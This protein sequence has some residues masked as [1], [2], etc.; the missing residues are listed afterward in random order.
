L[1]RQKE[2]LNRLARDTAARAELSMFGVKPWI[3]REYFEISNVVGR[4]KELGRLQLKKRQASFF[5]RNVV[6]LLG[7]GSRALL[8]LIVA[9]QPN[10]FEMPISQLTFLE[11]SVEDIFNTIGRLRNMISSAIIQDMFRIRNLFE[12]MEFK[13]KVSAP[14]NPAS[15]KSGPRGMKLEVKDVSFGYAE[16]SPPVIKNVSFVVE[17]GQIVSIV[18]YN[19]S[20]KTTLIR[21][22]TMLEKPT[23]GDIYINDI[24]VSEYDPKILRANMSILFQDFC[25]P[26][27]SDLIS[28]KFTD[29]TAKE[30]IGFGNVDTIDH[31]DMVKKAAGESGAHDFIRK[32]RSYFQTR[33][34]E[35][36]SADQFFEHGLFDSYRRG[37]R[38]RYDDDEEEIP[39]MW[40]ILNDGLQYQAKYKEKLILWEP[41][42]KKKAISVRIAKH[43]KTEPVEENTG[44]TSL[45]GGQWQRIAL[46]RAFM[47]IEEADLLILDEPSSALDPQAEYEV[48]KTIMDLRKNKTTIYIVSSQKAG[49]IT[50]V[51]SISYSAGSQ[52]NSCKDFNFK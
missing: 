8:Y 28:G 34:H 50:L 6:P 2:V 37:R 27:E 17:P 46:A 10:Y 15:Y 14:E 25:T 21:L 24:K 44:S 45:S 9:F 22:L 20:G 35:R 52:Q 31:F 16:D 19:G 18:G 39:F 1:N 26:F 40:K 23:S 3:I 41:R 47:R 12:C 30:N 4:L 32:F 7:S 36:Y 13:S 5:H 49:L 43:K 33:L 42:P 48:F 38:L 11:H 51:S 29:L